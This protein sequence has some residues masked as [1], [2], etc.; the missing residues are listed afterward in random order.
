MIEQ[1]HV[2]IFLGVIAAGL[3]VLGF[4]AAVGMFYLE[5]IQ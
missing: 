3:L 4:M 1:N 5:F 2:T